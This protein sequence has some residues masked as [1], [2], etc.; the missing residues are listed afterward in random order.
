VVG[1]ELGVV[2][3]AC[4]LDLVGDPRPARHHEEELLVVRAHQDA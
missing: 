1:V 4:E 2:D 3:H